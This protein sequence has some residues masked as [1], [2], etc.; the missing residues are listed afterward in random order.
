MGDYFLRLFQ[1]LKAFPTIWGWSRKKLVH[2]FLNAT[3]H[4]AYPYYYPP[5]NKGSF[6]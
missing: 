5:I 4:C 2:L 6:S 1:Y 3:S